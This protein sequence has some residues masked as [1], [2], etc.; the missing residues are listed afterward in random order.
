VLS[1]CFTVLPTPMRTL[2]ASEPPES[3][4]RATRSNF[5][6]RGFCLGIGG[7]SRVCRPTVGI[8]RSRIE[9]SALDDALMSVTRCAKA[10]KFA[11]PKRMPVAHMGNAVIGDR[12]RPNDTALKTHDAK[13]LLAQLEARGSVPS[14]ELIPV[15]RLCV[16]SER[17]ER[18]AAHTVP[19]MAQP[20]PPQCRRRENDGLLEGAGGAA[21]PLLNC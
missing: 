14:G 20:R 2:A 13:G 1:R 18:T 16:W 7:V 19:L 6:A 12:C 21:A 8:E 4:E 17:L 5:P 11:V 9:A 15:T 3:N 10:L